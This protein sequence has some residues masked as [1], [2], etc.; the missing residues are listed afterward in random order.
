[1]EST[2]ASGGFEIQGGT[3]TSSKLEWLRIWGLCRSDNPPFWFWRVCFASNR[4]AHFGCHPQIHGFCSKSKWKS[5]LGGSQIH[6]VCYL[7]PCMDWDI[8]FRVTQAFWVLQCSVY[9]LHLKISR[10]NYKCTLICPYIITWASVNGLPGVTQ[11]IA[12]HSKALHGTGPGYLR[13][14]L[15]Q[16]PLLIRSGMLSS[17]VI[18]WDSEVMLSLL[19]C[20]LF[21]TNSY[22]SHHQSPNDPDG[23]DPANLSKHLEDLALSQSLAEEFLWVHFN[24][25]NV[26]TVVSVLCFKFL[27]YYL[28]ILI[29][30]C[31]P[32]WGNWWVSGHLK[33]KINE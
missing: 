30:C 15:P 33:W 3:C 19:S 22:P 27:V 11:G 25:W 17:N 8:L 21:D 18:M 13:E 23:P 14:C 10:N 28:L 16:W 1:M 31:W 12:G 7:C 26:W 9:E 5:W 32:P 20:L 4:T 6:L 29:C 24:C 2:P